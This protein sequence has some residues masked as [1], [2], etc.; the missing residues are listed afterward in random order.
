MSPFSE[1]LRT[2]RKSRGLLLEDIAAVTGIQKRFLE[3]IEEGRISM[4]PDIY[5]RAFIRS[6][7]RAVGLDQDDMLRDLGQA[8]QKASVV[9]QGTSQEADE[10]FSGARRFLKFLTQNRVGRPLQQNVPVIIGGLLIA[11]LVILLSVFNR[12]ERGSAVKE[13]PFPE[14]VKQRER[15]TPGPDELAGPAGNSMGARPMTETSFQRPTIQPASQPSLALRAMAFDSVWI[16]VL[17]DGNVSREYR[18]PPRWSGSWEAV[19]NFTISLSNASAV[20]FTLNNVALGILG[21]PGKPV[22]NYLVHRQAPSAV[23]KPAITGNE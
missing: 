13:I 9:R 23:Q 10:A 5:I 20:S 7:A 19:D 1:K 16:R 8:E 18:V 21:T 4:L 14:V 6:Y 22:R 3:A 15:A 12:G 11:S 17:I 2:A